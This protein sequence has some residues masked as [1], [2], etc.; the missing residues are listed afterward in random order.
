MTGVN[1]SGEND[2]EPGNIKSQAQRPFVKSWSRHVSVRMILVMLKQEERVDRV[3]C[4]IAVMEF[5]I[6][7]VRSY[8]YELSDCVVH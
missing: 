1:T 7:N 6:N 5:V 4:K 8:I 2:V 3:E